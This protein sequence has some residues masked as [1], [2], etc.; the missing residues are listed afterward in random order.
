[1]KTLSSQVT[2]TPESLPFRHAGDTAALTAEELS[3]L[4]FFEG[5]DRAELEQ[6]ATH[7]KISHFKTG[8]M[9]VAQGDSA[10]RFYVILSGRVSVECNLPDVRL[11]VEEVGPGASVG[12]SWM[13]RPEKVHFSA[14]ALEPVAAVFFYGTLLR[15]DCE[16]MPHLGYELAKR[17]GQTMLERLESIISMI[18]G[19]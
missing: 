16:Q 1:M 17:A 9:L 12:F 3:S 13:F 4:P 2:I 19:K 8:E 10:D 11:K 5:L 18:G 14:R 15:S 7:T 6:I